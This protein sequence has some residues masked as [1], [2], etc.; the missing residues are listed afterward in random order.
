MPHFYSKINKFEVARAFSIFVG[1]TEASVGIFPTLDFSEFLEPP[2]SD[3]PKYTLPKHY[4]KKI[5]NMLSHSLSEF[6]FCPI[7]RQFRKLQVLH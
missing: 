2:V 3:K 5:G 7:S 4:V 6:K 1:Q